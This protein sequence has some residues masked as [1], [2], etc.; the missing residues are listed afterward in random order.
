VCFTEV[1]QVQFDHS[2]NV[3]TANGAFKWRQYW[4]ILLIFML[5]FIK[6]SDNFWYLAK[7]RV[8]ST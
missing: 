5:D 7:D 6:N 4:A 2:F 3:S 8:K 1:K